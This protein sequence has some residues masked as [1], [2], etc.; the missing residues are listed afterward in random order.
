MLRGCLLWSV[1]S[2]LLSGPRRAGLTYQPAVKHTPSL[3]RGNIVFSLKCH[4]PLAK[5]G[6]LL[7]SLIK[8][9]TPTAAVTRGVC[10]Q[11][12]NR[13]LMVSFCLCNDGRGRFKVVYYLLKNPTRIKKKKKKSTQRVYYMGKSATALCCF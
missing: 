8:W 10:A 13:G 5:T 1:P 2:Y 7:I 6:C 11:G 4:I 12:I 9:E 3:G